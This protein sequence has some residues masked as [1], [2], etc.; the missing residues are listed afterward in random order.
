MILSKLKGQ[1]RIAN[2]QQKAQALLR[3]LVESR[4]EDPSR[5]DCT[6]SELRDPYRF[7]KRM[8][9]DISQAVH[10]PKRTGEMADGVSKYTKVI[11]VSEYRLDIE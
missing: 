6:I 8:L 10:D 4:G 9:L 2:T 3:S 5:L 11:W 7:A 1:I